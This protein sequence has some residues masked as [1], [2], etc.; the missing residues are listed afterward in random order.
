MALIT[1]P[2]C[3]KQI[4]D[5]ADKCIHCGFPITKEIILKSNTEIPTKGSMP[6]NKYLNKEIK[7][8]ETPKIQM[9]SGAKK[10]LIS[11]AIFGIILIVGAWHLFKFDNDSE[12]SC[13]QTVANSKPDYILTA[14]ELNSEYKA[15]EFAAKEKYSGKILQISGHIETF[16]TF[17]NNITLVAGF[18][19][20]VSCYFEKERTVEFSKLSKGQLVTIKGYYNTRVLALD[21]CVLE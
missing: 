11:N 17:T 3:G 10:L 6:E 4:S 8:G 16:Y 9:S 2:E 14:E 18:F 20:N 5:K 19:S 15:N 12:K 1:C 13:T 7:F 21:C